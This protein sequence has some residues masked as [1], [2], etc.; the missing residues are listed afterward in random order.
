MSH[1]TRLD[2]AMHA[3]A[4]T[5]PKAIV[6]PFNKNVLA[7]LDS[8]ARA[9]SARVLIGLQ[10]ILYTR[11]YFNVNATTITANRNIVEDPRTLVLIYN[12][13][14]Y[15]QFVCK[16]TLTKKKHYFLSCFGCTSKINKNLT[17]S[18]VHPSV[19]LVAVDTVTV[20]CLHR[21]SLLI[22]SNCKFSESI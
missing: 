14:L 15:V 1:V 2:D 20:C 7:C 11:F 4:V 18:S 21:T 8:S 9:H 3:H 6:P 17:F 12:P 16:S 10:K 19:R 5:D 22:E 13:Q